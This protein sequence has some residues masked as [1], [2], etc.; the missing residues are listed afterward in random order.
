MT[1]GLSRDRWSRLSEKGIVLVLGEGLCATTPTCVINSISN[2]AVLA[3][4]ALAL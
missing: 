2:M 4:G 1:R 3:L